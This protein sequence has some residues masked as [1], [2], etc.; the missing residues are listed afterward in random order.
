MKF[1]Y[2]N[3]SCTLRNVSCSL[4]IM[5]HVVIHVLTDFDKCCVINYVKNERL[6][7]STVHDNWLTEESG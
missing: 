2:D 3:Q 5:Y 1:V 4:M 7:G 6:L